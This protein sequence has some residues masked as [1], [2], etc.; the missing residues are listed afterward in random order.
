MARDPV[1]AIQKILGE[2]DDL[3][4]RRLEGS[5]LEVPHSSSLSRRMARSRRAATSARM[6]CGRS[7]KDLIDIADELEAPP[8]PDDTTH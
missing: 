4:R 5:R 2:A 3:I 8:K 1:D 6:P 7:P